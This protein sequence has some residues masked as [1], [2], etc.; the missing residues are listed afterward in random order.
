MTTSLLAEVARDYLDLRGL[1]RRLQIAKD[2]LA[3]QQ[4]TLDLTQSLRQSGFN[5]Q[6]DVARAQTEVAQTKSQIVPLSTAAIQTEHA[7]AILLGESPDAL[8]AELDPIAPVPVVPPAVSVGLPSDLLRRRPDLRRA[9]RQLAAANA[10]I[11]AAISDYYPKF[12]LTGAFGT[13][14]NHF[15][16]LFNANSRYFLI[17]PSVSWKLLDFGRTKANVD[18]ARERYKQAWLGYQDSLLTA[19]RETEDAIV[20]YEKEQEHRDALAEAVASAKD[21]VDISRDQYKQGL[22]DFLQVL[23]T[24]RQLLAAQDQLAQSDEAIATNLVALYKAL[25]GG[26]EVEAAKQITAE[27]NAEPR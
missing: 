9:E 20:A 14:S 24:Q 15:D 7:I 1:Q 10:R 12:S 6:L 26:W 27:A 18:I 13:D 3:L 16:S 25:G 11:G 2:N 22:V 19:L 17:Y 23:D 5:T 21:A 4:D 8:A